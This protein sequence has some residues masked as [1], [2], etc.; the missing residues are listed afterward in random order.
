MRLVVA[1]TCADPCFLRFAKDGF[2]LSVRRL[3]GGDKEF[4]RITTDIDDGDLGLI[5][6]LLDTAIDGF[7][8]AKRI[9]AD[10]VDSCFMMK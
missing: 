10:G 7:I 1:D 3:D 6:H 8:L 5:G 9:W 2:N 4:N